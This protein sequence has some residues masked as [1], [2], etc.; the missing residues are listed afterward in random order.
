M[1]SAGSTGRLWHPNPPDGP[2]PADLS[3][4]DPHDTA[5]ALE[6]AW[7]G[8]SLISVLGQYRAFRDPDAAVVHENAL[9]MLAH[10]IEAMDAAPSLPSGIHGLGLDT[11]PATSVSAK[12][13]ANRRRDKQMRG[14]DTRPVPLRDGRLRSG[15]RTHGRAGRGDAVGHRPV[16]PPPLPPPAT[17]GRRPSRRARHPAAAWHRAATSRRPWHRK[18][19]PSPQATAAGLGA[20]HPPGTTTRCRLEAR[21]DRATARFGAL[22]AWLLSG[23]SGGRDYS[24][25]LLRARCALAG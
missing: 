11:S 24:Y 22:S 21:R 4:I 16:R 6:S 20:E 1:R 18:T 13:A 19:P 2:P 10:V 7:Y 25:L 9:P 15:T 12:P 3:A 5:A 23:I 8:F 14:P 17:P